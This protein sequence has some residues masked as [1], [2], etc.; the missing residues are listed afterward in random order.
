VRFSQSGGNATGTMNVAATSKWKARD[1][2][3]QEH[4]EW[5]RVVTFGKTAENCAQYLAKG[6][7]V[8]VEGE[9]RT[10]QYTDRGGEEKKITELVARDVKFLSSPKQ[11]GRQRGGGSGSGQNTRPTTR[12]IFRSE[13]AP[14]ILRVR[15]PSRPRPHLRPRQ[16]HA[17][18]ARAARARAALPT[19]SPGFYWIPAATGKLDATADLMRGRAMVAVLTL[20]DGR[21]VARELSR[22]K[23]AASLKP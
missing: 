12:T 23:A 15:R 5:F 4:T 6:S 3:A 20:D 14:M 1:G 22:K 10:R 19:R 9:I 2:S 11:G 17:L 8:Y 13:E 18:P 16:A 7:K 21:V